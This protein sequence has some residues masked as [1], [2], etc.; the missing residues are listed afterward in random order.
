VLYQLSYAPGPAG[1]YRRVSGIPSAMTDLPMEDVDRTQQERER[2]ADEQLDRTSRDDDETEREGAL[3][4][5]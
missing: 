1:L 5:E 3:P 4:E 2:E